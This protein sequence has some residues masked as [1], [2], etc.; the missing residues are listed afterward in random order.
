LN[1]GLKPKI[2]GGR[3]IKGAAIKAY[4]H[5]AASML[6]EV[7]KKTWHSQPSG[8]LPVLHSELLTIFEQG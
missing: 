2:T 5:L 4:D 1:L 6:S 7:F 8:I 3:S